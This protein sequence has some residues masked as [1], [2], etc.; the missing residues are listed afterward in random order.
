MKLR[1]HVQEDGYSVLSYECEN[2]MVQPRSYSDVL[3]S[4]LDYVFFSKEEPENEEEKSSGEKKNVP[5]GFEKFLKKT[6]QG[7]PK[8]SK[9]KDEEPEE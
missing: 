9:N 4:K 3:R 8:T 7:P 1:E 6:R 2:Q 5:R